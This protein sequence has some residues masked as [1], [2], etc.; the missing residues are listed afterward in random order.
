M[1]ED[2][3]VR[4]GDVW[5]LTGG[6][7]YTIKVGRLWGLKMDGSHECALAEGYGPGTPKIRLNSKGEPLD[8]RWVRVQ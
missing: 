4:V 3:V 2:R 8:E 5:R 7:S 1:I 6:L